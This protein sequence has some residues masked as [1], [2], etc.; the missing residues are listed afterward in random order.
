MTGYLKLL[1]C[2]RCGSGL[3]DQGEWLACTPC[4]LRYPVRQGIPV[5]LPS[6]AESTAGDNDG[7]I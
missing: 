6:E 5:M 2:P 7:A 1:K 3:V 4:G